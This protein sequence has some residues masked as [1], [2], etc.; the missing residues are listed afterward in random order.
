MYKLVKRTYENETKTN[1]EIISK[2]K[3]RIDLVDTMIKEGIN[4]IQNNFI[5]DKEENKKDLSRYFFGNDKNNYVELEIIEF[6]D[7]DYFINILLENVNKEYENFK[8]KVINEEQEDYCDEMALFYSFRKYCQFIQYNEK[9]IDNDTLE[10]IT[11]N[12]EVF[13]NTFKEI[14]WNSDLGNSYCDIKSIII[15]SIEKM[16]ESEV[17]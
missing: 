9:T 2:S 6:Y 14:Y 16:I 4:L 8:E 12:I 1:E 13:I 15:E 17:E 7:R 10:Y 3:F 11:K 5:I